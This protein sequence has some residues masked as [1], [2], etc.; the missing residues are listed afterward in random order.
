MKMNFLIGGTIAAIFSLTS[1]NGGGTLSTS[2]LS[3]EWK[4]E[5]TTMSTKENID[6]EKDSGNATDNAV[7]NITPTLKFHMDGDTKGGR[8]DIAAD[9]TITHTAEPVRIKTP[10]TATI[11]GYTTAS[12]TWIIEDGDDVKVMVNP[13]ETK[14]DIDTASLALSFPHNT[15]E[16]RDS[17]SS[18]RNQIASNIFVFTE[19]MMSQKINNLEKFED[20]TVTD[21]IMTLEIWDNMITFTKQ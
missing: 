1:C 15:K 11:N 13:S 10:V 8:F 14:V 2:Q 5:E 17:I 20:V 16:Q 21:N 19:T 3:G 9:F 6:R 18:L 12:G 7:I 4:G